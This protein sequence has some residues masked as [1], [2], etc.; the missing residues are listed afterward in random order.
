MWALVD[1]LF[2]VLAPVHASRFGVHDEPM[3]SEAVM[4][5]EIGLTN[6]SRLLS[7][8]CRLST[9][10]VLRP[11]RRVEPGNGQSVYI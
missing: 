6:A 11:R 1:V 3:H 2:G 5:G 10:S 4:S 7:L 8:G 9:R